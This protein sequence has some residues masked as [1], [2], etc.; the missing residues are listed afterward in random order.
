M[1]RVDTR[2]YCRFDILGGCRGTRP[3]GGQGSRM[4]AIARMV[5]TSSSPIAGVPTSISD[6]PRSASFRAM[7]IFSLGRKD[8]ACGLLAVAKRRIDK[9]RMRAAMGL[10]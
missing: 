3:S 10:S 1:N 6:T 7:A 9:P 8:D 5:W 2:A 4:A